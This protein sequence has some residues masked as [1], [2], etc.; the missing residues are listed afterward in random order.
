MIDER[1]QILR[2]VAEGKISVEDAERLLQAIDSPAPAASEGSSP[3]PDP[4]SK[5]KP[6][7][8]LINVKKQ[9]AWSDEAVDE[10]RKSWGWPGFGGSRG[11]RDVSIRVPM[12]LVRG[13]MRLGAILPGMAGGSA[14]LRERGIDLDLSKLD[15]AMIESM[16]GEL[17]EMNIDIDSGRA[18]VKIRC[19]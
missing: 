12:A 2:M 18:Q 16:L 14:R 4:A 11:K 3:A 13:G 5:P 1:R 17:G 7:F 9:S 8:L 10:A 19:E 15:P 6:R